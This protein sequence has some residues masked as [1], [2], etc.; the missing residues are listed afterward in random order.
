MIIKIFHIFPVLPGGHVRADGPDVHQVLARVD[1]LVHSG[2]PLRLGPGGRPL[3]KRTAALF[4]GDRPA[5]E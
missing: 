2:N 4:G 3:P 1:C 5:A